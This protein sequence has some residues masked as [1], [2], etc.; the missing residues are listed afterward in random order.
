MTHGGESGTSGTQNKPPPVEPPSELPAVGGGPEASLPCGPVEP[1]VCPFVFVF[2]AE[3]GPADVAEIV[4]L[5]APG[6]VDAS[7]M[8]ELFLVSTAPSKD[9]D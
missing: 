1:L 7:Q 6:P 3:L 2:V 9:A 4:P 5:V 8:A